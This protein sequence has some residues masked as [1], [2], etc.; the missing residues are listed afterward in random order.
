[1]ADKLKITTLKPWEQQPGE[2]DLHYTY[3]EIY[4]DIPKPIRTYKELCEQL[5]QKENKKLSG[6]HIRNI[7]STNQWKSRV[8]AWDRDMSE[9]LAYH[10]KAAVVEMNDRH[11]K[12]GSKCIA[13]VEEQLDDP[14]I[15]KADPLKRPYL[16]QAL[17]RGLEGAVRIER[18]SLGESTSN[19]RQ[20]NEGINNLLMVLTNAKKEYKKSTNPNGNDVGS[21]K[22]NEVVDADYQVKDKGKVGE[23][24][25]NTPA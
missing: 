7:G 9:A 15:K 25:T 12:I 6:P 13:L 2:S 14:G 3:F 24:I 21:F 20:V 11:A 10:R 18:L 4:R 19:T 5:L 23:P 22:D 16:I 8:S 1:M 17:I